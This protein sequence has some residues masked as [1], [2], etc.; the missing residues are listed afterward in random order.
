MHPGDGAHASGKTVL[1]SV[2]VPQWG[3]KAADHESATTRVSR[4]LE[5]LGM[6]H[7]PCVGHADVEVMEREGA[8]G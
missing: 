6:R 1:R 4:D 5:R 7:T 8:N 3:G 2:C